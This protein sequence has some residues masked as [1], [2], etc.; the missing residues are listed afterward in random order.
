MPWADKQLF[1][2]S[3]LAPLGNDSFQ[4][5]DIKTHDCAHNY[6]R[7]RFSYT[8]GIDRCRCN[9]NHWENIVSHQ[10]NFEMHLE[11]LTFGF[12][13]FIHPSI[14]RVD[15]L[16]KIGWNCRNSNLCDHTACTFKSFN[17]TVQILTTAMM[18]NRCCKLDTMSDHKNSAKMGKMLHENSFSSARFLSSGSFM[19]FATLNT[20]NSIS[21]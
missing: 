11:S 18:R 13:K 5:C 6:F 3:M 20:S 19:R 17:F 14:L 21:I 7:F 8:M 16:K 12:I 15:W 4:T 2:S 10:F 9:I 1:I